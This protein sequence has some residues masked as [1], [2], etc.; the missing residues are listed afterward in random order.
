MQ[1]FVEQ[2]LVHEDLDKQTLAARLTMKDGTEWSPQLLSKRLQ[3][4]R[5]TT[6]EIAMIGN[7]VGAK[8]SFSVT[9]SDG[10]TDL[11]ALN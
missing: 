2:L 1:R 3:T 11:Y 6:D 8:I 9:Y 7:A 10:K 5:L 4:G